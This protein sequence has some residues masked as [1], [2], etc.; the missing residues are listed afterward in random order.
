[1]QKINNKF[2]DETYYKEVLYNGLEVT[3]FH[4]PEFL[5]TTACFGTPYGSLNIYQ[6]F[7]DKEYSFNPG[8]AHFLEHK[9]F[10][11]EG[12]DI[13]NKFSELGA[14]VNAFT[15]YSETVYFFSKSGEDID[16]CLNLLLDFVQELDISDASVEKEKGIICEELSMYLQNPDNQLINESFKSLYKNYPLKFD[17]GGDA[18]SVNKITKNELDECFSL[19]YHPSNMK[20]VITTPIDP[21]R[22]IEIIRNNQNQKKFVLQERPVSNNLNEPKDVVRT[23]HSFTMDV[24]KGKTCYAIKLK[25][26]FK[27]NLEAHYKETAVNTY[28]NCYFSSLNPNYQKWLDQGLI[29]DF[30][31]FEVNFD[32]EAA[33]ILFYMESDDENVLKE[34]VDNELTKDLINDEIV[35]QLKRRLIGSSFKI[36]NDVENFTTGYIRDK[37]NGIDFFD[38]INNIMNMTSD[39][40][41]TIFKALDLSNYSIIHIKSSSKS[42]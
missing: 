11:A 5:S 2:F 17:I 34:I 10:E 30:F 18:E 25:P 4:K 12:K 14:N 26:D 7:K 29:N 24:A 21:N 19:N 9:L 8:I 6:K 36:F 13:L 3:I 38:D 15:S 42:E 23:S 32:K 33:F 22:I 35:E 1:M 28:L 27:D 41:K 40:I 16:D 20:L 31:G 39:N 37:L